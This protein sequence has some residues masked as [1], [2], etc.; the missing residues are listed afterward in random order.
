MTRLSRVIR[1]S[2]P[3]RARP[4]VLASVSDPYSRLGASWAVAACLL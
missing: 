4:A 1:D 3:P 2:S